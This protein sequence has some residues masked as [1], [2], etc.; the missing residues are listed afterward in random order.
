MNLE[1]RQVVIYRD[2]IEAYRCKLLGISFTDTNT[3]RTDELYWF[4]D[5]P[6]ESLS[7]D[8]GRWRQQ[9]HYLVLGLG[10]LRFKA[11]QDHIK[12]AYRR[13]IL[14][15]H[16]D[17]QS[18]RSASPV[19]Q[20]Q[21]DEEEDA[22]FKCVQRAWETL[23]NPEKRQQFDSV[24]PTFSETIPKE[25]TVG[26]FF[27]LYGPVFERN[28]R[29]SVKAPVPTLGSMDTP[30]AEVE[31]FYAFWNEFESWRRFEYLDE[32]D[33]MGCGDVA[34]ETRADKRWIERKN[35]AA[36][37]KRKTED[38]ARLLKLVEQAYKADPRVKA[39]KEADKQAKEAQKLQKTQTKAQ[40]ESEEK[41]QRE[42]E[43]AAKE[44]LLREQVTALK[45][46]KENEKA[47]L[48]SERRTLREF[49]SQ[50][51]Y[52]TDDQRTAE[53]RAARIEVLCS[54]LNVLQLS[55]L[56]A[57][58]KESTSNEEAVSMISA[59]PQKNEPKPKQETTSLATTNTSQNWT[60]E[61][62]DA[63]I[64]AVKA[65]P[66]GSAERWQRIT[67]QVNRHCGTAFTMEQII[68]ESAKLKEA[69]VTGTSGVGLP[70]K[71]ETKRDPRI[72][73]F[74]PT[75]RLDENR[76]WT[77]QEQTA[78]EAAMKEIS[79][80]AEDRWDRVA[81]RVGSRSKKECMARVREIALAL[82]A[83]RRNI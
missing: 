12:Q 49:W 17:K 29:F 51:T 76:P 48:K 68:C 20:F 18:T 1:S 67:E 44:Q 43:A 65:L 39:F 27:A 31:S 13:R 66:P 15:Y 72:A 24:D 60:P 41:R 53:W 4:E 59:E 21:Q 16:P 70:A 57:R 30:R 25:T 71:V 52:M 9:D 34:G 69:P 32:E 63:L 81:E 22:L 80:E 33:A 61:A 74:T 26:D 6:L 56:N 2:H 14:Q 11:N 36:R 79:A 19:Y 47:A 82:K 8:P 7:L 42:A 78:L 5:V 55:E 73:E 28:S 75:Q 10:R 64:K 46:A 54:S 58:L 45:A 35:R 77:S 50:R 3:V 62:I 23:S 38:N 40:K 37:T 83:K